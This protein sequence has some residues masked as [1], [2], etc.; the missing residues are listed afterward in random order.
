M[1]DFV[2]DAASATGRVAI[3]VNNAG[4]VLGQVGRPFEEVCVLLLPDDVEEQAP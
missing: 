1:E 4:G 3:H 2:R